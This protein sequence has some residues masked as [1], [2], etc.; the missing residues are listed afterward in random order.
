MAADRRWLAGLAEDLGTVPI[1]LSDPGQGLVLPQYPLDK[2]T[3]RGS[4]PR[5]APTS[6]SA[7]L[8]FQA[9]PTSSPLRVL[10]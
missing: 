10:C 8:L 9:A 7:S 1:R 4:A 5:A 6:V 3:L 2:A